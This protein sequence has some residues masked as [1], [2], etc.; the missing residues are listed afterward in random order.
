M[1]Y[2]NEFAN[3]SSHYDLIDNP[4]VQ[5]FLDDC[6]YI[7][8]PSDEEAEAIS[9]KFIQPPSDE[10]E[11]PSK[12]IAIDGSRHESSIDD[13]L[14][15][16][17][18]AFIKISTLLINLTE[19]GSLRVNDG[20]FV[21]PFKMAKIKDNKS[22][23]N[24]T[25]PS[26][27]VKWQGHDTVRNGI[28]AAIDKHLL[29]HKTRFIKND[30]KTSLRTT[31]FH[32][33]SMRPDEMGT[34]NREKLKIYKC[35]NCGE[36]PLE[37]KDIPEQQY[38]KYCDSKIYP[39]DCL[40]LWEEVSESQSNMSVFNRFMNLVEHL[41]PIHYIRHLEGD[42][43]NLLSNLAFFMD[44][45]L[46]IFGTSAWIHGSIMRYL[47]KVNNKLKSKGESPI[48]MVG[49]Q[50]TGQ[51]V[52]YVKLISPYLEKNRITA[53]DDE[54]RYKYIISSREPA[55]SGFGYE[56]YYGQD[57]IY[58]TSSGKTFVFAIPYF[59]KSKTEPDT[60]S[61]ISEK[62]KFDNYPELGAAIDLIDNFESDLYENALIPVALAH[63]YTAISLS[64]GGKVL[65]LLS[66]EKL[67][68]T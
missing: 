65:D 56:T 20:R 3:K 68:S 58:K 41:L 50:K 35:P 43:E 42:F 46:A 15:S 17:K 23:L 29:G 11:L 54:F 5:S 6:E 2:S 38:C 31:L 12:I 44:G 51:V 66:K 30:Y 16:T 60:Q 25:L 63:R 52:D 19:F 59:S 9:K 8:P 49:L 33:A 13:K 4:D 7:K 24:F 10:G 55:A 34:S 22:S 28:R 32:L 1:P 62:T 26:A 18:V 27:N 36:G 57:F 45:P 48:L 14:P 39:S 64:P 53:I 47:Y 37:I 61:F 67:N 21:D 40:R